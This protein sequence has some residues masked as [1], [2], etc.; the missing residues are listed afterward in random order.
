MW[1]LITIEKDEEFK[2]LLKRG[3]IRLWLDIIKIKT[4]SSY[5]ESISHEI[6]KILIIYKRR[7]LKRRRENHKRKW[8]LL[9][10]S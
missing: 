8:M 7:K 10:Q 3:L 6:R 4:Q 5:S 2:E 9:M 1:F